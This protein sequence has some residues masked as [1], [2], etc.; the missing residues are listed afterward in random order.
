MADSNSFPITVGAHADYEWLVTEQYLEDLLKL[1][2]EIVL[3]K[4]IA[5]TSN[6]SG[7]FY[8][9]E[10]ERAAGWQ[11]RNGIAYGPKVEDAQS[12]PRAGWDEWFVFENPTDLGGMAPQGSNPFAAPLTWGGV[13][14]FVNSNFNLGLH[15][16]NGGNGIA[17]YFWKQFSWIRPQS[18]IAESDYFL[19]FISANKHLFASVCDALTALDADA[20][21]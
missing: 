16:D 2:P 11:I 15:T 19:T 21:S 17:P 7:H 13:H 9:T 12:L 20:S 4:Y 1:C 5:V 6:D 18:Y 14:A 10:E 8:P 3:G